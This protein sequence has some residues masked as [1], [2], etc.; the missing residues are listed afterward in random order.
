MERQYTIGQTAQLLGIS[1]DTLRFYEKKG[2][3]HPQKHPQNAYRFY[4]PQDI[5]L[6]LDILFY[7]RLDV[8]VNDIKTIMNGAS[9]AAAQ[10]LLEDKKLEI[11]ANIKR[12][13]ALLKKL[14]IVE[15]WY[16][17]LESYL[18]KFSVR[19]LPAQIILLQGGDLELPFET[20]SALFASEHFE[21]C[22]LF[23]EFSLGAGQLTKQ[24]NY[25]LIEQAIACEIGSFD[26]LSGHPRLD[27]PRCAYTILEGCLDPLSFDAIAL[28]LDWI[29]TQGF[30]HSGVVLCSSIAQVAYSNV[31]S[32]YTEIFIPLLENT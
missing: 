26:Q 3:V 30:W 15:R 32:C 31:D 21:L 4:T 27:Y 6:L 29:A 24:N 14:E 2:L 23:E 28:L 16:D 7:R 25:L 10:K 13:K 18:G 11:R 19:A 1:A 20:R 22:A 9:P 5:V 12:Q 8:S 17:G